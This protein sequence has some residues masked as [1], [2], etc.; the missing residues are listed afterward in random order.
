[1]ALD[2]TGGSG[3]TSASAYDIFDTL[4]SSDNMAAVAKSALSSGVD[5]YQKKNYA[6]A[7]K[8]FQRSISLDPTN[9]DS[10]N[11]LAQTY[12]QQNKTGEA[13][14]TYKLSLSIDQTQDSV[15]RSLANIYL[16]QKKCG[17]AEKAY[18]ASIK[19]NSIDTVAPYMLGQMYQEM[20]RKSDAEVQ[21]QKVIRMAPK[22][23]NPYYALGALYNK[24]GKY[25]DAVKQ[26]ARAVAL[27]PR[28]VA[29]Q[30]EFGIAYAGLGD[31]AK[32]QHQVTLVTSLDKTQGALLK[33]T[34]ARPKIAAAAF[35]ESDSFLVSLGPNTPLA[36]FFGID[37]ATSKP[38]PSKLYS[39]TFS[40]DSAMDTASVQDPNNWTMTKASGG[41]A[42]Y[43]NNT[44]PVLPTEAYIPQN[45]TSISYDPE[46]RT[47]TVTFLMT[48][49]PSGETTLDPS[50]VVFKFSG[51]D[52]S[53]KVM[54]PAADEYDGFAS[55]PF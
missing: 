11:F 26:L 38:N 20:G 32:A 19:L 33:A 45:P 24:E 54:D 41:A 10:Y 42:G 50:H 36:P 27:K 51:K 23:A 21:F 1:M 44:L 13:I 4:G 8:E 47:A 39:L 53:G 46:K 34:I 31:R 49:N 48:L 30:F 25:S 6:R 3:P 12:L 43:Y 16:G 22:D 28:M 2:A 37:V 7:A 9:I 52:V 29:A 5:F 40:F 18:K 35:S 14:K 15:Q 17:D 55:A